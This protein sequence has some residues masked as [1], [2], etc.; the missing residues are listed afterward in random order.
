M[1]H[2]I[3]IALTQTFYLSLVVSEVHKTPEFCVH[4]G[5]VEENKFTV[6]LE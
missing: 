2:Y 5:L 1:F 6:A 3:L 4:E